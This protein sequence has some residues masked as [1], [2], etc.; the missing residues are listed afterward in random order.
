MV[1][2]LSALTFLLSV[3]GVEHVDCAPRGRN[4]SISVSNSAEPLGSGGRWMLA[5]SAEG[6]VW[7]S[8]RGS[9][10]WERE[11][12]EELLDSL[13]EEGEEAVGMVYW[14]W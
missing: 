1:D 12:Q 8:R 7:R 9:R 5:R 10:G 4:S 14:A 3:R 13:G 11:M 2:L 6:E